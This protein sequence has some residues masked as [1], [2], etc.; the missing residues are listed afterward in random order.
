MN[1]IVTVLLQSGVVFIG[2]GALIFLLVEPHF[3]GRNINATAYE[4][5]FNDPFLVYAYVASI[6][7]FVLLYQVFRVIGYIGQKQ[8]YS[9]AVMKALRTI[10]YCALAG[11]GFIVGPL[12][13][14]LIVRPEDDIVGGVAMSILVIVCFAIAGAIATRFKRFIEKRYK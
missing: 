14:L 2:L 13:Y 6:S 7:L 3:E 8:T 5:Y 1:R 12:G 9:F 4:V 10:Q 11:V